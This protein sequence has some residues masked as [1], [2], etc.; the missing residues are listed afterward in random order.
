[1]RRIG[2]SVMMLYILSIVFSVVLFVYIYAFRF[3]ALSET[4]LVFYA[5][6]WFFFLVFGIYGCVATTLSRQVENGQYKSI[7]EAFIENSKS[8]GIFGIL[9]QLLFFPMI[10]L[11]FKTN[12][13]AL[14]ITSALIWLGGLVLFFQFV[15][16]VL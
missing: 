2:V 9:G 4:Q 15:F 11:N 12:V 16:P 5:P 1:M 8:F 14:T 10:I 7:R 13:M 3:D 6:I